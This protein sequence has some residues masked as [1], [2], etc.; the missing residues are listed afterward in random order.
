[1]NLTPRQQ[2]TIVAITLAGIAIFGLVSRADVALATPDG[3]GFDCLAASLT[4]LLTL[5]IIA[6][7]IQVRFSWSALQPLL[8]RLNLL[9]LGSAFTRLRDAG[10]NGPIWARR[11]NLQSLDIPTRSSIV[12]HN[13]RILIEREPVQDLSPCDLDLWRQDY[14][15]ALSGLIGEKQQTAAQPVPG[16]KQSP[17]R[18]SR[19]SQRKEFCRLRYLSAAISDEILRRFLVPEWKKRLLPWSANTAPSEKADDSMELESVKED[20]YDSAQAFVAMQFSMFINYGVRQIQNLVLAVSLCFGFL[21][22]ALNVYGFQSPQMIGRFLLGGFAVLGFIVWKIMSQMERD[23]I[24]SRLSGTV[25]GELNKEFYLKL[26]G[27]GT[28][29]VLGLLTS[30]FPSIGNFLS[31]WVQPSLEAL[32]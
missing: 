3:P 31:S 11:L 23:P 13:L 27:Y 17:E 6:T 2:G 4:V 7:T 21:V 1:M 15:A 12:L 19:D 18:M 14:W 28:L 5:S 8:I 16:K 24:L 10:R 25:E 22:I 30:V 26:I 29:P 20:A 9:P 32:R